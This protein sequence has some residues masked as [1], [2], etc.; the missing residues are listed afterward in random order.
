MFFATFIKSVSIVG[1]MGGMKLTTAESFLYKATQ[2]VTAGSFFLFIAA[3]LLIFFSKRGE[4]RALKPA[5]K[6]PKI[7][8]PTW[9]SATAIIALWFFAA[10]QPQQ[11]LRNLAEF[12]SLIKAERYAEAHLHV[13][14][15]TQ[16]DF[17]P[18]RRLFGKTPR[19]QISQAAVTLANHN[20]WPD[21]IQKG[22]EDDVQLW[23]EDLDTDREDYRINMLRDHL[24]GAP[25]I[26]EF[27]K[28][29][30]PGLDLSNFR[31][32]ETLEDQS[33]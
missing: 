24:H 2:A 32:E 4:I 19:Y 3:C 33:E 15:L 25:H 16:D 26:E 1:I 13:K 20:R 5:E 8:A 12:N 10:T 14:S 9:I 29:F 11:R 6:P 30:T 17:P 23:L 21:W 31:K 7:S 18:Y 28:T 27:S 22:L